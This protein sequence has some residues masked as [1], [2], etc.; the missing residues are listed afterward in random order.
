MELDYGR[1][2]VSFPAEKQQQYKNQSKHDFKRWNGHWSHENS[3]TKKVIKGGG[4]CS[5]SLFSF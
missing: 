4:H 2:M 3:T 1:D 5:Q